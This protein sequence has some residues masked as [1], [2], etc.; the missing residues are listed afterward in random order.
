MYQDQ[1]LQKSS[2][3]EK[4]LNNRK[5]TNK[6]NKTDICFINLQ[7]WKEIH[8][9]KE[10]C[11]SIVYGPSAIFYLFLSSFG[12]FPI[13]SSKKH[14]DSTTQRRERKGDERIALWVAFRDQACIF[15]GTELTS[16]EGIK[17]VRGL[18]GQETAKDSHFPCFDQIRECRYTTQISCA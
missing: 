13:S 6:E 4:K 12:V 7:R 17:E 5:M 3:T 14:F 11:R 2:A 18:K 9:T 8:G 10:E 1:G 16:R 15:I